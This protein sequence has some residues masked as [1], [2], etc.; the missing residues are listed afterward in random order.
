MPKNFSWVQTIMNHSYT[1]LT[2][3]SEEKILV[4]K[5]NVTFLSIKI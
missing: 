1:P 2:E 3:D 4:Y 5:L